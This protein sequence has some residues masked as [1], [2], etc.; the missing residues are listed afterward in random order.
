M[1]RGRTC[2]SVVVASLLVSG[3]SLGYTDPIAE[4]PSAIKRSPELTPVQTAQAAINLLPRKPRGGVVLVNP[5]TDMSP[6]VLAAYGTLD[7]FTLKG[8]SRIYLNACSELFARARHSAFYRRA[9][10]AVIWHEMAHLDGADEAAAQLAEQALW[11]RYIRDGVVDRRDGLTYLNA[12][13]H[14]RRR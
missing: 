14:R 5:D 9:L 6:E 12:M 1:G 13:A 10:A 3:P 7:G 4:V 8:E 11:A 2:L